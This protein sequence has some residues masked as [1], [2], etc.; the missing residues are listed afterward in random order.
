[1]RRNCTDANEEKEK[2]A[3]NKKRWN[4]NQKRLQSKR[5]ET[6]FLFWVPH[7]KKEEGEK[8]NHHNATAGNFQEASVPFR[9]IK[10]YLTKGVVLSLNRLSIKGEERLSHRPFWIHTDP[11]DTSTVLAAASHHPPLNIFRQFKFHRFFFYPALKTRK[12][13]RKWIRLFRGGIAPDVVSWTADAS[14]HEAAVEQISQ[15]REF[16]NK[17]PGSY[18][19][20]L[21]TPHLLTER[22][23]EKFRRVDFRSTGQMRTLYIHRKERNTHIAVVHLGNLLPFFPSDSGQ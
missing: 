23:K 15:S 12:K 20:S 17:S 3:S 11:A 21:Y 6:K 14:D 7:W 22:K 18:T 8:D 2:R 13:N 16:V 9:K 1:V 19:P 10:R 5:N 4:N